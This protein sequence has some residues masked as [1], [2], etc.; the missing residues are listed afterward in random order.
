MCQQEK[1]TKDVALRAV[2]ATVLYSIYT[3]HPS[4]SEKSDSIR[5]VYRTTALASPKILGKTKS[6]DYE[7]FV[8]QGKNSDI[9]GDDLLHIIGMEFNA[10]QWMHDYY[11]KAGNRRAACLTALSVLG[12][13]N[14]GDFEKYDES[15]YIQRLD[16][17]ISLYGDLPEAGEVA[18]ERYQFMDHHTNASAKQKMEFLDMAIEKWSKWPRIAQLKNNRN[19]LVTSKFF[20]D[21]PVQVQ[22]PGKS[23][24]I[25]LNGLR[26]LSSLTMKVYRTQLKGNHHLSLGN[27]R[28][29]DK[30]MDGAVEVPEAFQSRKF[31]SY[32]E[33]THFKDSLP[34]VGLPNG[35]YVL[36]FSTVPYTRISVQWL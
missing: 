29:L 26:H 35:V 27:K 11:E 13:Q 12:E 17:L 8:R 25:G 16:S 31:P 33:Y 30:I 4:L 24:T 7:P 2:Y 21:I 36:E 18:L 20:A 15:E 28:D 5:E 6:G 3:D 10:W 23:Q 19:Q 22:M 34:L 14:K 32:K 9:Y 1:Q